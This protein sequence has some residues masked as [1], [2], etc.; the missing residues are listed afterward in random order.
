MLKDLTLSW[1]PYI[2]EAT[3]YNCELDRAQLQEALFT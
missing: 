3:T 2:K 1:Y